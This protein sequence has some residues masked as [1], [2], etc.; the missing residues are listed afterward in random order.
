MDG[1]RTGVTILLIPDLLRLSW[2]QNDSPP[3]KRI[4]KLPVCFS[5]LGRLSFFLSCLVDM[6]IICYV[7]FNTLL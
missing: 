2:R 5:S 4:L 6:S 3:G 7:T 1:K